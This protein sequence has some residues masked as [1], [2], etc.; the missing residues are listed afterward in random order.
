M[1]WD[2]LNLALFMSNPSKR[3]H[4]H[5]NLYDILACP[6]CK[7]A[8]VHQDQTLVC[9]KCQ[10]AYPIVN[11]VPVLFPDGSVPHIQH[12]HELVVRL[13]YDPWEHRVLMQSMPPNA[14]ILDI[15]AGN[16]AV[17]LPNVIR[18]DVTLTPYVEVVGDAHALPFLPESIDYILSL[19]VVEHLR[20]PFVAVQEMY[21]TLR[22]GGYVYGDC[23]FVFH[24]HG[25]PHHYFNAT[26]QGMEQVFA[27]FTILSSGVGPFQMPSFAIRAV[28]ETYRNGLGYDGDP[29]ISA[30]QELLKD[31]LDRPLSTYDSRFSEEAALR[32]AAGTFFVGVKS[33]DGTSDVIPDVVQ[34]IWKQTPELQRRFPNILNLRTADNIMVWAKTEGRR[35]FQEID[36][37]FNNVVPFHKNDVIDQHW[38]DVFD[39]WPVI[40]PKF[41]FIPDIEREGRPIK[42]QH[43]VDELER[44]I[45]AKNRHIEYLE[46]LIRRLE[47]GRVMRLLGLLNSHRR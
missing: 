10:Q 6:N 27:P 3:N 36:A 17:N 38:I 11:G 29:E 28:L 15:G 39:S 40:E 22:N 5:M 41:G 47:N 14:I 34:T 13:G 43:R 7:T 21:D 24:Y 23:N 19:A 2:L 1:S 37:Y 8:V 44:A 25:Y 30:V 9:T 45:E 46:S 35:Q 12:E 26:Q 16:M 4:H 20:Q 31:L 18:M 32:V 42:R 33:P